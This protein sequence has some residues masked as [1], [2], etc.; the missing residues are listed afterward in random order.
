M[1]ARDDFDRLYHVLI[2]SDFDIREC[3]YNIL[4]I[5]FI[6][7]LRTDFCHYNILSIYFIAGLRSDFSSSPW[8]FIHGEKIF[9]A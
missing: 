2:G 5:N 6:A 3:Y 9:D 4:Y 8:F 1:P 7:G